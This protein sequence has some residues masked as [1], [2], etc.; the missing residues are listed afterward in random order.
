MGRAKDDGVMSPSKL[1][2]DH[3]SFAGRFAARLRMLR[4]KAKLTPEEAARDISKA[5]YT[6]SA[7]T[8]YRWEQGNSAPHIEA[9]P[10]I[11]EAYQLKTVRVLLPD[12]ATTSR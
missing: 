7:P 2:P 1:D 4:E 3:S 9:F 5:G 6:V 8:I 11:A 12:D 10:A